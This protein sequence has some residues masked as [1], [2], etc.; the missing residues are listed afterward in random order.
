M[1][2][3]DG[4]RNPMARIGENRGLARAAVAALFAL[5]LATAWA[6]EVRP[7]YLQIAETDPGTFSILWKQPVLQD[8]R[9]PIDPI[10]PEGCAPTSPITREVTGGALLQTWSIECPLEEGAIHIR[11]LSRTITDVMVEVRRL[12]GEPSSHLLRP[13]SPSLDLSDPSPQVAA[14]LRLGVEHLIFGI[15]HVLFVIGLVLFIPSRWALLKTITAFTL[16]HSI[17][18]ALSV[19]ELVRLPQ[20]PVEAVIALSILFLARELIMPEERRSALTRGRPWIMALLFG[21]LH[22]FGFAGA[23]A[24]I[25]LPRDQLALALF[26]FNVGIEIGQIAIIAALLSL[27]W[28]ARRIA[29]NI[30]L[31]ERA[32]VYAMGSLAAFWTIDRVLPLL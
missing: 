2:D 4:Q 21:L 9:L 8:R 17:T 13:D 20:G 27:L 32:F 16:A 7:A 29:G 12:N 22:G 19:L 26:L 31:A 1:I 30:A 24:D 28:G 6:H 14:Y 23:L 11:G 25:G 3:P 5:A 18:L 15:D 10:F